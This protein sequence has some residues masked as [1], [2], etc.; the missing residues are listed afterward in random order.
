MVRRYRG[1]PG[2]P[3]RP[4]NGVEGEIFEAAYCERC[5]KFD[6]DIGCSKGIQSA[7]FSFKIGDPDYPKEWT[8]DEKGLPTCTEF[9]NEE[10]VEAS[11]PDAESE[12]QTQRK[13]K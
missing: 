12:G 11:P 8:H 3:Y 7:A 10:A 6:W 4:A 9:E 5:A 13:T 1:T 2:A